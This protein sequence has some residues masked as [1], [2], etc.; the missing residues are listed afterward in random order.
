MF[1][2]VIKMPHWEKSPKLLSNAV[3]RG[4]VGNMR[5]V[6]LFILLLCS[7]RTMQHQRPLQA[8]PVRQKQIFLV[9]DDAGLDVAETRQFLELPIPMTIAVLPHL[10][11]TEEVC[12][13]IHRHADK[14]LI[15]HQPMEAYNLESNTGPGAISNTTRPEDVAKILDRNLASVRGAVGMNNHMGSRVT[16]NEVL[17]AEVLR[18]CR[19]HG[20]YFLD[21]KTSY[22]SLVPRVARREHVHLEERDVFLDVRHDR[23]TVRRAWE[24]TVAKARA[25][26]YVIAIGHIWSKETAAAISDSYQTLINQGYTFH[27]LSELYK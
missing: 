20:L 22:N 9:I 16:E 5:F 8:V 3:P 15:L 13:E 23:E 21:S 4:M 7:C 27:T 19:A 26:G 17:M 25:N 6:F 14:E 24:S 12:A 18:Y 10:K 11:K 2:L 1:C